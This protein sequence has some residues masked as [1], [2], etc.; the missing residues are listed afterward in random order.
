MPPKPV[1]DSDCGFGGGAE[2]YSERIDCLRSGRDGPLDVPGVDVALDGLPEGAEAG[3]PKKSS[4]NNE[5][6]GCDCLGGAVFFAGGGRPPATSVVLGLAGGAG[7]SPNRST[8]GAAL[9][10]G[11]CG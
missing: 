10:I 7:T 4:P 5:S 8:F 6:A 2:A 11:G 9:G 3:P 1:W